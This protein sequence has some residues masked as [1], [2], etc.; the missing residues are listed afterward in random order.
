M[1][2]RR[3]REPGGTYFFTVVLEDRSSTLLT[4]HIETLR[5]AF[6]QTR[7]AMPF[8]L[9]AAVVLPE[10][11]HC[12]WTLPANDADFPRR[13][14]Y[15]KGTF[16]RKLPRLDAHSASRVKKGE[17]GIWQRRYWEHLIRNERDLHRHLDYIHY[18]PVKHGLVSQARE[19]PYSSFHRF[20]KQGYYSLDWSDEPDDFD[21]GE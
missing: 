16:S 19:W 10:H 12:I 2:Y 5:Q 7:A 1:D 14:R 13:W 21:A 15:I 4:D 17:R 6:R 9:E 3:I 11:L 8:T 20:V 18:N